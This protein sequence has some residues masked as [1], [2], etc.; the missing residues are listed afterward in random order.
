MRALLL[1]TSGGTVSTVGDAQGVYSG[2]TSTGY[3]FFGIVLPTDRFYGIYGKISNNGNEFLMYGLIAG[4]GASGST[5]YSAPSVT[6]YFYTGVVN[7][8]SIT[9]T[10]VAGSNFNGTLTENGYP[11]T[12]TGTALPTS[13][14]NYDTAASISAISGTWA[15]TLLDGASATVTI[16]SNGG[17]SGS[18]SGCSFSGAVAPDPSNKNFFDV[19]LTFGASPCPL[20]NEIATGIA[21]EYSLTGGG[22]QLAAAVTSGATGATVFAAQR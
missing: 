12:L 14:F 3:S 1:L 9:A 21:V 17:V 20:P 5:T 15:G 22:S 6:D 10:Y 4:Q 13:L 2:T 18:S 19:L 16:T 8:G 7:N 11:T